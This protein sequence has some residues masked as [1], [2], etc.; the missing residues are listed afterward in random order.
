MLKNQVAIVTGASRGIGKEIALKFAEQGAKLALVG[1]SEDIYQTGKELREKGFNYIETFQVDVANEQQ[2]NEMVA[3]TLERFGQID[4]LVNNAGI[5]FFKSIESTT[6]EE[7]KKVFEVNVQGV[8]IGVKA[9]LPHMKERKSGT[10]ITISS[11]VGRY[12]I[13]NGAAYTATKY[14]VQG[15]SGSLAQE[16]RN[17]GIRVGTINPGMVDTYFANSVQGVPEKQ[18]WLKAEDVAKAVVYMAGAPKHM[19]ID[20]IVLHPLIQQYPIA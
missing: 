8:F 14:A 20:E 15:F 19:L 18:D 9:V 2:M 10:I 3:K 7:W 17:Y 4:I 11:D 5:G 13:P 6:I 1:S 16:V 12:T